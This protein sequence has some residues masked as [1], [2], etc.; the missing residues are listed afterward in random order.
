M[1]SIS[2]HSRTEAER[3]AI[4][5]FSVIFAALLI[6][7]VTVSFI[8]IMVSDQDQATRNDLSQSAYDSAQAGVEDAKR[9]LLRFM[10]A[11][12]DDAESDQCRSAFANISSTTCN[13]IVRGD[14]LIDGG[15]EGEKPAGGGA[16]SYGEIR[17][18]QNEG[19]TQLE[20][21]YTCVTAELITD[22]YL[23][24][25]STNTS[26][27]VPLRTETGQTFDRVTVEWFSRDD[28]GADSTGTVDLPNS[29]AAPNPLLRNWVAN[30]PPVLR[31]QLMQ[32]GNEF[33]LSQF[34]S[35]QSAESNANT[36]FLYPTSSLAARPEVA[37][38]T[39]SRRTDSGEII[40]T[41]ASDA[42]SAIR[43]TASLATGG[44][45]CRT[46]LILPA[47]IGGGD[48]RTA[49]LRLTPL[50]N[51]THFRVT[52]QQGTEPRSFDSVQPEIDSTGR[53]NDIF[54]R[55]SS[56][57]NLYDTSFPY[58]EAA[59]DLVGNLCKS[60]SV[61]DTRYYAGG[62]EYACEP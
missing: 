8:R 39:D 9:A 28:L 40:P 13:Q 42:L 49:F 45:S 43:C 56:R 11:C 7:V 12:R 37:F 5:I 2:R 14:N 33:T 16:T 10:A 60:F 17:V 18:Q 6:T 24:E 36:L 1:K 30:R 29:I 26:V 32:V 58:P 19:D 25:T 54:R 44:Y 48:A 62:G 46:Q 35:P 15:S 22:D 41:T 51:A 34:D 53:A 23:G 21:A 31:A 27:L 20:Q 4:S 61:T 50:Y 47:P 57:V 52:M 55:I 3:G 38:A 59:V